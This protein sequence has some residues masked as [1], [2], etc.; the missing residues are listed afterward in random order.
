MSVSNTDGGLPESVICCEEAVRIQ[1]DALG[2]KL[3]KHQSPVTLC[4]DIQL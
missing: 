3:I 1:A 4:T 2:S